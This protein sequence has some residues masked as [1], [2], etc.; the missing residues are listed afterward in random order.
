MPKFT[1]HVVLKRGLESIEFAPGDE[2]PS[3]AVGLVG[4]HA[5]NAEEAAPDADPSEPDADP[6]DEDAN[7]DAGSGANPDNSET[8][9]DAADT[10]SGDVTAEAGSE[11]A[12]ADSAPDFTK[13]APAK[14]GR[15]R[16]QD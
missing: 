8:D 14:R 10:D 4:T 16:K 2:L 3:W 6:L 9:G 15:P 11:L 13:P 7:P 5:L 1:C 12:T